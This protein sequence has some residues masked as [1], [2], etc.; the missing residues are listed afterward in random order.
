MLGKRR[1][2]SRCYHVCTYVY[3]HYTI[4]LELQNLRIDCDFHLFNSWPNYLFMYIHKVDMQEYW[5]FCTSE[6]S[7]KSMKIWESHCRAAVESNENFIAGHRSPWARA[8]LTINNCGQDLIEHSII[9]TSTDDCKHT[10]LVKISTD[11]I[12][13]LGSPCGRQGNQALP[14]TR[15]AAKIT[16]QQLRYAE[17]CWC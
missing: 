14:V 6:S 8:I 12:P 11:F 3:A 7:G 1:G 2:W 13:K 9:D 17:C 16:C 5:N 4:Y 15:I 10:R